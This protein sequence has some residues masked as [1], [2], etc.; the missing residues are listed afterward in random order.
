MAEAASHPAPGSHAPNFRL[1]AAGGGEVALSDYRGRASVVLWFS[2]GLFCPYCKRNMARLSQGYVEIQARD[3]EVLQI[4]HNTPKEADLYFRNYRLA[5]PYLCDSDRAVHQ[6]YGIALERQ[7]IGQ[8]ADRTVRQVMM[9]TGDLLMRGE[10][11]PSPVM[12]I[13]RM[14]PLHQPPQLVVVVDREG[15]VRKVQPI[16]PFDALPTVD[17]LVATLDTLAP[18][19]AAG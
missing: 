11:S 12:P 10:K 17:D 9:V 6:R 14:G 16:G 18:A 15:V 4:T 3:A 8:V 7:P 2:K 1:H 13:L 19:T 5:M